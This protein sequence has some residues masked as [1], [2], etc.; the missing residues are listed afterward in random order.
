MVLGLRVAPVFSFAPPF[1]LMRV[2]LLFRVLFGLALSAGLAA[3]YP[4][5]G[6]LGDTSLAAALPAAARE[7]GLG[8]V[9]VLAFNLSFAA[10]QFAGRVVDIQAGFGLAAVIDPVTKSQMP[11]IGTLF[12]YATGAMFFAFDG[13]LELLKL[14]GASLDAVPLGAWSMP[15]SI[16]RLTAFISVSFLAAFGV[17]ASAIL[18]LFLIDLAIAFLSRTVPQMNVLVFGFQVKTI[19][20]L[21]VLPTSFGFG[22]VLLTR[23]AATMLQAIPRLI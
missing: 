2:P 18:A 17:A 15:H 4:K 5:A 20:L 16:A 8:L 3:A 11:L 12:A 22:G 1:T 6:M 13:H 7:L 23:M 14:F 21:L 19:A 9:F 10:L